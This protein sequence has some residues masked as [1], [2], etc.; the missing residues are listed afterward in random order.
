MEFH[1]KSCW[2]ITLVIL[3]KIQKSQSK[4]LG[5]PAAPFHELV[6]WHHEL[7]RFRVQLSS[8]GLKGRFLMQEEKACAGPH[9]LFPLARGRWNESQHDALILHVSVTSRPSSLALA[10][11]PDLHS[12]FL[13]QLHTCGGKRKKGSW[14]HLS[15]L[16][17]D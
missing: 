12:H 10:D 13:P 17:F 16:T 14:G 8:P 6:R 2:S 11:A 3:Q 1:L 7:L 5:G 15:G 4:G 9:A